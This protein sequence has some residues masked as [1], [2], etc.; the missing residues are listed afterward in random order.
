MSG[1]PTLSVV[2]YSFSKLLPFEK[3]QSGAF[4]LA[5]SSLHCDGTLLFGRVVAEQQKTRSIAEAGSLQKGMG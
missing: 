3:P 1:R 2:A 4:P 5:G